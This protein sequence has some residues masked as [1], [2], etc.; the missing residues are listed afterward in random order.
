[1]DGHVDCSAFFDRQQKIYMHRKI[2]R[3]SCLLF[4]LLIIS[5]VP[6]I[7]KTI[8]FGEQQYLFFPFADSSLLIVF[9]SLAVYHKK[10][11]ARHMRYM[12]A[13]SL[14]FPGSTVSRTEPALLGWSELLTQN[15]QYLIIYSILFSLLLYDKRNG[16][17]YQP[18]I[19]A[20]YLFMVHQIVYHV[21]FL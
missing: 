17:K 9:Y 2:G 21:V 18:Y 5:F 7:I 12:I 6:Q 11:S 15:I 10:N 13:T 19:I 4:P 20:V 8:K 1:M 14:V 3:L 16:R